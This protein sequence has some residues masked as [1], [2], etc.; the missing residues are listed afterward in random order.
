MQRLKD[1]IE[2]LQA[3][4][5][6]LRQEYGASLDPGGGASQSPASYRNAPSSAPT[7][8]ERLVVVPR[9]RRCP[10]FNGRTGLGI[11]EWV[12]EVEACMRVRHLTAVDRALFIF[13]HLEGEAKQEIKFRSAAERGDPGKILSILRELYGC[14]QSYITL[15]QDFFARRQMEGES[16]QEFSLA[17]MSLMALVEQQAPDGMPNAEVLLRDQFTEHVLDCALRRELKQLVRRQPTINLMELRAEAIRWERE[18]LPGGARGRSYSL[19][20][21]F[22]LQCGMQ[23]RVQVNTPVE[24]SEPTLTE[25]MDLLKKQQEQLNTL[26]QTVASLQVPRLQGPPQHSFPLVCRRCQRPGHY[27]RNCSYPRVYTEQQHGFVGQGGQN[28]Q[29]GPLTG[30][31]GN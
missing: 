20:S 6:Q 26:T 24:S 2:Q 27:A 14:H 31:S 15:Q 23:G 17:L 5:E 29:S 16:L 11:A 30:P 10:I 9:D 8:S 25:L 3:D 18:G 4:N 19:P 1:R 21:A 7:V 13:D 28:T 12:E 22:G